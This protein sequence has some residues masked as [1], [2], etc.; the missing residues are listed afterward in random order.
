MNDLDTP[1]DPTGTQL[2]EAREYFGFSEEEVARHL[3]LSKREF[4]HVESGGRQPGNSEL[5]A[6]AK[7][8]GTT[9]EFLTGTDR[10]MPGWESLPDLDE[11][12]ADLSATDRNEILRFT[13]FLCSQQSDG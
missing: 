9:V 3:G 13:Q 2:R 10:A 6:L 12:S 4:S 7:L 5:Q 11:A 1:L 8:Y